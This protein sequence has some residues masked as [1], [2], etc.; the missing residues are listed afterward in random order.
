MVSNETNNFIKNFCKNLSKCKEKNFEIFSIFDYNQNYFNLLNK[1]YKTN[2]ERYYQKLMKYKNHNKEKNMNF[3]NKFNFENKNNFNE[4]N[5]LNN[6]ND[7]DKIKEL[8]LK[9]P[10]DDLNFPYNSNNVNLNININNI[11]NIYL[12]NN[13]DLNITNSINNKSIS[14]NEDDDTKNEYEKIK[15][16][17]ES[18]N[19]EYND[20]FKQN[21]HKMSFKFCFYEYQI[22]IDINKKITWI[23]KL[24]KKINKLKTSYRIED[25]TIQ[26]GINELINLLNKN[27]KV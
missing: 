12:Q 24:E 14:L 18:K 19:I 26:K 13:N 5:Y 10:S 3:S 9:K 17:L 16:L 2:N 11:N 22:K 23:D 6:I 27:S 20:S 25:N 15:N 21:K 8:I 4:N 7:E 1:K